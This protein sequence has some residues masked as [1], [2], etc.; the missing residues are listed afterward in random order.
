MSE[1]KDKY[2]ALVKEDKSLPI[3]LHDWWLDIVCDGNWDVALFEKNEKVIASWPYHFIKKSGF[4]LLI[5]PKLT[6]F[7]GV[8]FHEAPHQK[9]YDQLSWEKKAINELF[10][11]LPPYFSLQQNFHYHFKNWLPLYWKKFS[12]TVA[13]SYIIQAP[14]DTDQLFKSIKSSLKRNINNASNQLKVT[15][16]GNVEVVYEAI[17][18]TYQRQKKAPPFSKELLGRLHESCSQRQCGKI[19]IAKDTDDKVHGAIYLV[20]D[21]GSVYYLAGGFDPA[22][23]TNA[24]SYLIW[25]G[26]NFAAESHRTF[27]FEGSM[28]EGIEQF[29]RSFEAN[30]KPYFVMTHHPKRRAKVY[31]FLKE[32]LKH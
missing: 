26:I 11:Q 8:F 29:F 15:E 4:N 2:R 3:F 7:L 20:W 22:Y 12:Q 10:D 28:V 21:Q 19:L 32:I 13:Y 1:K 27:D 6:K 9:V 25:Q 31:F 14:I 23:K 17:V 30:Q 16:T 18:K 5:M 24:F